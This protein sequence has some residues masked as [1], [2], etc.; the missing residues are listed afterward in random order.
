[1]SSFKDKPENEPEP[2]LQKEGE[3]I[4]GL[5]EKLGELLGMGWTLVAE[6]C[7]LESCKCPLFKSND[8]NLYCAR[9]EMWQFPNKE[10]KKEKFA[11]VVK[12]Y[13]DLE[14]KEMNLSKIYKKI[15]DFNFT[16]KKNIL[17]SLRMKLAYLSSILNNSND[18]NKTQLILQNIEVCENN[19]KSINEDI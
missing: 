6:S 19:I 3:I 17:N 18:L 5:D 13:Q 4:I 8:G 2:I 7:P 9:C 11:L 15:P 10:R 16:V 12:Q 14:V 1:M